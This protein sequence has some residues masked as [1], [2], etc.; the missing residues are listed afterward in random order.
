MKIYSKEMTL[1][2]AFER[3]QADHE[4]GR[5]EMRIFMEEFGA[6]KQRQ[7]KM[8]LMNRKTCNL[9]GVV[10]VLSFDLNEILLETDMGMLMIRGSE[11]HVTRLSLEKGEVDI[12]GTVD[13]LTYSENTSF[14]G[15]SESFLSKLFR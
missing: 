11:M 14:A 1:L 2:F 10:D 6:V 7:H 12:E 13:S 4:M 9:G 8:M 15:K 3:K 5:S